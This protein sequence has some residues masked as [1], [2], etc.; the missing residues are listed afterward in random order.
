MSCSI[1]TACMNRNAGLV[2]GLR[3]WLKLKVDEIIV[4]DWSSIEAVTD[5]LELNGINDERIKII[6]VESESFW[7]LTRA[8]NLGF[9][10][11]T[12][13]KIIKVDAEVT[14]SPDFLDKHQIQ[15]GMYYRGDWE[16][17]ACQTQIYVN[18]FFFLYTA[19]LRAI[20]GFNE[21]IDLYGYDDLDI[22]Q[23][24]EGGVLNLIPKQVTEQ[25]IFHIE[26]NDNERVIN[27]ASHPD[28]ACIPTVLKAIP[29][30]LVMFNELLAKMLP[31][32]GPHSL[33][34]EYITTQV[35]GNYCRAELKQVSKPPHFEKSKADAAYYAVLKYLSW[36]VSPKI[37]DVDYSDVVGYLNTNEHNLSWD[38]MRHAFNLIEE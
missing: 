17:V 34:A 28:Y 27:V 8:F 31:S 25:Y 37:Y 21:Y 20:N 35:N 36:F 30:F 38:D 16:K 29:G 2:E 10:F 4:V 12:S 18:G 19:D 13:E 3:S 24:L 32:W 5:T 7:D 1:V 6:R 14:I 15:N 11:V 9:S 33:S 22:Y 23:R 26:H